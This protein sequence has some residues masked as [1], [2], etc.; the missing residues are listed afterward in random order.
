MA[1]SFTLQC[2]YYQIGSYTSQFLPVRQGLPQGSVLSPLLF[3]LFV[4]DLPDVLQHATPH[5]YADDTQFYVSA[6]R[7]QSSVDNGVRLLRLDFEE[8]REWSKQNAL[9][10][11]PS[12]TKAICFSNSGL[13][14]SIPDFAVDGASIEWSENVGLLMNRA[15]SWH[16]HC[17]RVSSRVYVGLRSLWVHGNVCS[18]RLR[19]NLGKALLVPHFAYCCEVF[20]FGLDD[21]CKK[22]LRKAFDACTRYAFG[23]RR[24]DSVSEYRGGILGFG[25]LE[26]MEYRAL[27]FL[28]KVVRTGS[29]AYL[30]EKFRLGRST[31]ALLLVPSRTSVAKT[32]NSLLFKGIHIYN[33]LPVH[34]RRANTLDDF[35]RELTDFY[36]RNA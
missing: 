36:C 35:R 24:R 7:D 6:K 5:M 19:L 14:A 27:L 17:N 28:G 26:Y 9:D 31:R 23:V 29:P 16:T 13:S 1:L 4:N 25:I 18:R 22:T 12:K 15:M 10:L 3:S 34:I 21:D 11:N 2:L 32:H 30:S 33:A 8:V 20:V